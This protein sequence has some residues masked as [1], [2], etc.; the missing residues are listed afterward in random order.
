MSTAHHSRQPPPETLIGNGVSSSRQFYVNS[1]TPPAP[2]SNPPPKLSS[3]RRPTLVIQPPKLPVGSSSLGRPLPSIPSSSQSDEAPIPPLAP[4]PQIK[5]DRTHGRVSMP[6]MPIGF[7]SAQPS[8]L[9]P[10]PPS[11]SA[12]IPPA[13]VPLHPPPPL[14][15]VHRL[16]SAVPQRQQPHYASSASNMGDGFTVQHADVVAALSRHSLVP[17]PHADSPLPNSIPQMLVQTS[18]SASVQQRSLSTSSTVSPFRAGG[19]QPGALSLVDSFQPQPSPVPLLPTHAAP[20][21]APNAIVPITNRNAISTVMTRS[22]SQR[23]DEQPVPSIPP[24]PQIPPRPSLE[25]QRVRQSLPSPSLSLSAS[26]SP[27]G[28]PVAAIENGGPNPLLPSGLANSMAALTTQTSPGP[29][30]TPAAT[31]SASAF[32]GDALDPAFVLVRSHAERDSPSRPRSSN[33]IGH[34][35]LSVCASTL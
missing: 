12:D 23:S 20:S 24:P 3:S 17:R 10:A 8:S 29:G 6:T 25:R 26:A 35:S 15:V 30:S 16:L 21:N 31:A 27:A 32:S 19:E 33:T 2:P 7:T 34:A 18:H 22:T 28:A 1:E 5:R 4:P 9:S 13:P 14:P 11:P